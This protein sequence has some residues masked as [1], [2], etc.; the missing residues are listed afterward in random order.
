[1]VCQRCH[2]EN[3]PRAHFCIDCGAPL[4]AHCASCGVELPA[5][6]KF[7]SD[8]GARLGSDEDGLRARA[9]DPSPVRRG[10]RSSNGGRAEH[11]QAA[12]LFCDLVGSAKLAS[13]L[14]PEDL[15]NILQTYHEMGAAVIARFDGYLAQP[16]G[17]GLL[18]YFGCPE[19]HEDDSW[20]A[21]RAGLAI[22]EAIAHLNP[23]LQRDR[24]VSLSARIGIDTGLVVFGGVGAGDRQEFLAIGEPPNLASRLKDVAAPDTVVITQNTYNLVDG[25][26][27]T[28]DL[29][30]RELKGIGQATGVYEVLGENARRSRLE[31]VGAAGLT[32]LAGREA[33]MHL[34][35]DRWEKA[36]NGQGQV[37]LLGGEPGIGKSRLVRAL[38]EHVLS[39]DPTSWL[40]PCHASS[41]AQNSSFHPIVDLLERVVL[42]LGAHSGTDEKLRKLGDW[43]KQNDLPLEETLPLFARLLSLPSEPS[44]EREPEREKLQIKKTLLRVLMNRAA[45]RP[46]LFILEDLHWADPSTLEL[47]DLLLNSIRGARILVVLTFRPHEFSPPDWWGG[48]DYVTPQKLIPLDR[49]SSARIARWAA[50]GELLSES[51]LQQVLARA[52]GNPL[53]IE[54]LSK[55]VRESGLARAGERAGKASV[56]SIP[57][58]LRGSLTARL[59]RLGATKTVAQIGAALGRDFSYEILSAV[60]GMEGP[61]L[62]RAL[63][64]LI[65][66]EM[67]YQSGTPPNSRYVFKHALIQDAAYEAMLKSTRLEQHRRIADV[68][69]QHFADVLEKQ[70]ELVAHHYTEA[71]RYEEAIKYWQRAG[72]RAL[73]RA[74]NSEAIAHFQRALRLLTTFSPSRERNERELSLQTGLFPAFMAIKGWASGEVEATCKRVRELGDLLQD[75][76]STYGSRWGLWTNN[77][78]RGRLREA[79]GTG[80]EVLHLAE[81]SGE[82]MLRVMAHHAVGYSHFY[83]GEFLQVREHAEQAQLL[84]DLGTERQ[85]VRNFQFSSSAALRI[86]LGSSL[87]MLGYPDQAPALVESGVA[88]TRTLGHHPSEAFALAASLLLRAYNL[89]VDGAA[90]TAAELLRLAKQESFEIWT[91]FA[92]MFNGW[93]LVE[94]G[95][96]REGIEEIRKGIKSWQATGSYLN[97]TITMAMLGRSLWRAGRGDEALA[98]LDAEIG[99]AEL[100]EELHFAPEIH[101]LKGEIFLERGQTEESEACF[102]GARLLARN[103]RARMLELRATTSLARVWERTG[104][105]EAASR[106]IADCYASFTEGFSTPDLRAAREL[107]DRLGGTPPPKHGGEGAPAARV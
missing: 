20:R 52:D 67:L 101:R 33:E 23:E 70:P 78:L 65:D 97:Q 30:R 102:S 36:Q 32:P 55:L 96:D 66:A 80:R 87:W 100:R 95:G 6:A 63:S 61:A 34:L 43:L 58:T 64:Q 39:Q 94:R 42:Q 92:M 81:S 62:D 50:G 29:G 25:Y 72:R 15:M 57:A 1:M 91:P 59:D 21:V 105:G 106:L 22:L 38:S 74:A 9:P 44:S 27:V 45:Q 11:R 90:K 77:F 79:L 26:F 47:L 103:Q 86:M 35:R 10:H 17:D 54:E 5:R 4:A 84:F 41:Y 73:D 46:V 16:L 71:G 3:A 37:V 75:F 48:L 83:R 7:C 49:H 2:A 104:R 60:S 82:P 98:T 24:G 85:I 13:R 89:D 19:A 56:L 28:R 88:L 93:V 40:T 14:D 31:A 8:C 51:L 107:M 99:E 76:P 69:S 68:L 18:A 53:F 12:V